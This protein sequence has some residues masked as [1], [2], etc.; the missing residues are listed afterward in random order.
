MVRLLDMN[1]LAFS[2]ALLG[3]MGGSPK[4]RRKAVSAEK[5]SLLF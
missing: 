4:K 3:H 1:P 2:L 5:C